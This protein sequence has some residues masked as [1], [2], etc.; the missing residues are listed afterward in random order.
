MP[1]FNYYVV[2][3]KIDYLSRILATG[4]FSELMLWTV[5]LVFEKYRDDVDIIWL[6]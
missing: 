5:S 2:R 3:P 6:Y 4:F 1:R